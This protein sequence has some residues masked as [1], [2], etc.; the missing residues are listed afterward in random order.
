[1]LRNGTR[2]HGGNHGSRRAALFG[3][4]ACGLAMLAA[5]ATA[6]AAQ[7]LS[8][9][10]VKIGVLTD[11]GGVYSDFTGQGAVVAARMAVEDF[12]KRGGALGKKLEVV[13][14]DHQNKAD[15]GAERARYWYERDKVDVIV[16]LV[17][18][19]VAL[20][21]MEVAEQKNK[22]ALVSGSASLPITNERCNA[23][24]V[25]WV[26]DTYALSSGTAKSVVASGKPN[27]YFIAADYAF[28]AAMVGDASEIIAA[29]GGKV[30]GVSKH[31]FPSS[32]FSSY[33]LQAQTS[34][35]DVI[36]LANGG[37]DTINSVKQAAEF[38]II[39]SKQT[40][41]PMVMFLN[42]V[43]ALGLNTAQGLTLTE[44]FYW[45]RDD[46]TRAWSR[47]FF[48]QAQKMPSMVHAGVY[49]SVLN[50]LEAV[51]RTGT[52]EAGAVM[53]H[54]KS[55]EIDDGLFKGK[56]RVDGKFAHEMLLLE[57]KKPAESKEPWDYY[58]VKAVIPADDAT[59]P[60]S[61]SK[62]KL[63]QR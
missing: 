39:G 63:V 54:L 19:N 29:S 10:V 26:Y 60:L 15:I 3:A 18:T 28:G 16:E 1:M 36:A 8:D 2:P 44:G 49:S 51:E 43:H 41:L 11:M 7:T 59:L 25:H 24:T 52:D 38:G 53:K 42:D 35:A 5:P 33:L 9:D 37:H 17:S 40:V 34:K 21:V 22:L 46:R 31:P 23:N 6:A 61:K 62:C 55:V 56:I 12:A 14:A 13:S 48:E 20:A 4:T 57:V 50:Y 47:R 27:W 32:D 58:H 45:N 30:L